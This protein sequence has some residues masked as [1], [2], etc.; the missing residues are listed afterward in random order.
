MQNKLTQKRILNSKIRADKKT[1]EEL[2][3]LVLNEIIY[4]LVGKKITFGRDL[5]KAGMKLF[6]KN[7]MGTFSADEIP[8]IGKGV[9]EGTITSKSP[10]YLIANLD[11]SDEPGSHWIAIA[12]DVEKKKIW[13]YDSFG[14][15]TNKIIPV[16][17]KKFGKNNL[18]MAEDDSEQMI[19]EEDC[20]ARSL[21]FL[22]V[23]DRY[24]VDI[25]RW[26]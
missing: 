21:A 19:S 6:G 20:G 23:F 7:Y 14:R 1:G 12:F 15:D 25:A 26:I 17:A 10:L 18:R 5:T 22:Y 16:L 24:G 3:D 9:T 11:D 8:D 13:V 2:Y 4:P